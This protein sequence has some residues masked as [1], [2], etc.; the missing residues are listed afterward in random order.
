MTPESPVE[1]IETPLPP[2]EVLEAHRILKMAGALVDSGEVESVVVYLNR[3][4]DCYQTLMS[5]GPSRLQEA[6][7]LLELACERLGFVAK[8]TVEQMIAEAN[9]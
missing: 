7:L 2:E 3:R 6:G 4:D 9:K 5:A 1:T 8:H